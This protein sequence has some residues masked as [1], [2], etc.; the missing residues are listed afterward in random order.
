MPGWIKLSDTT[1]RINMDLIVE[2]VFPTSVE[3]QLTRVDGTVQLISDEAF[4]T[5]VRQY[6]ERWG[7]GM[8]S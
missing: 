4:A 7:A 2:V 6:L 3:V 5:K 8:H 1:K